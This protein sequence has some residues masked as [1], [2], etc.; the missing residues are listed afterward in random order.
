MLSIHEIGQKLDCN[1]KETMEVMERFGIKMQFMKKAIGRG[2]WYYDID[3]AE[4][5]KIRDALKNGKR[6]EN[7]IKEQNEAAKTLISL[8]DKID[9]AMVAAASQRAA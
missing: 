7:N 2:T 8:L 5:V 9:Y 4:V 3:M 1:K 6:N